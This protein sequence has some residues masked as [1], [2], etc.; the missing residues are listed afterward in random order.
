M[1]GRVDR[2]NTLSF[3]RMH[4]QNIGEEYFYDNSFESCLLFRGR[5]NPLKLEWRNW[6][7]GGNTQCR[8]CATGEEETQE[9]FLSTCIGFNSVRELNGMV[10]KREEDILLFTGLVE[11]ARAKKYIGEIWK[12]RNG[13]SRGLME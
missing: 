10:G 4:K 2:E 12:K 7:E 8:V 6:F 9:H 13:V 5:S 11:V 1:E 3:Y